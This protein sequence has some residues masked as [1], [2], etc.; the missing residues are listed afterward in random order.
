VR[1]GW[2]ILGVC[3]L[4]ALAT[5][6]AV[7]WWQRRRAAPRKK[8]A[9]AAPRHPVVLAHGLMGFDVIKL[10]KREAEYFRGVPAKLRRMGARVDLPRVPA[11]AS[12]QRRAEALA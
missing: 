2:L 9:P 6:A 4:V 5:A 11:V 10:G 7:W 1:N 12:I 8:A 3:V